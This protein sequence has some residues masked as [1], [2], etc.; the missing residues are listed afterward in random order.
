M[1]ALLELSLIFVHMMP[2]SGRL[3]AQTGRSLPTS[4]G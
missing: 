2:L 1:Q 4:R 3:P